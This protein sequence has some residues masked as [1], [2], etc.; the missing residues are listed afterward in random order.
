M[1]ATDPRGGR[2]TRG[3]QPVIEP[4]VQSYAPPEPR[5]PVEL[6]LAGNEGLAPPAS[7]L[8]ELRTRVPELLRRYPRPEPL[9]AQL[10]SRYGVEPDQVLVTAGADESLD[11]ICRAFLSPGRTAVFPEPTFEMLPRYVALTGA[12]AINPAWTS[13]GYPVEDVL[14]CTPDPSLIAIVTPNNPT[15]LCATSEDVEH[16]A[17]ERPDT[18]VL[19]DAAYAEFTEDDPTPVALRHPNTLVTRTLSKAYGLAGLRVGYAIGRA[20]L[21]DA[22]RRTASPFPC[23]GPSLAIAA[24]WLDGDGD[25]ALR[26]F[27]EAVRQERSLLADTLEEF[28][29]DPWR[30]E[31][32]FVTARAETPE[33]AQWLRDGLAA[34]GIAVRVWPGREH[35]ETAVR[36]TC[37]G[38]RQDLARVR[39]AIAT[40]LS[41]TA[42]APSEDRDARVWAF[43]TSPDEAH[44]A[45]RQRHLPLGICADEDET[46]VRAEALRDAGCARVARSTKVLL[47]DLEE[48][49]PSLAR[50]RRP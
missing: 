22:L 30:G 48:V 2:P 43:V 25:R 34:L 18:L 36:I 26:A 41:P 40:V 23:S 3:P 12:T 15:G 21:I 45:R 31:A 17:T 42:L 8:D 28:G 19:L 11:R 32:N 5:G 14:A 10:A 27:V 44:A 49:V 4:A 16:I 24:A 46:S 50:L 9:E 13:G 20:E 37:P 35:L 38:D 6:A 39:G 1:T 33:R 7:L 29:F 47:Q